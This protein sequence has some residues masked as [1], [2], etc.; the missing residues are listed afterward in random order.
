MRHDSLSWWRCGLLGFFF[1][2]LH[3]WVYD[4]FGRDGVDRAVLFQVSWVRALLAYVELPRAR[5]RQMPGAAVL[6]QSYLVSAL[7][8]QS[9]AL[10]HEPK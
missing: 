6:A 8:I 7:I 10:L 2:G 5:L 9:R 3:L 1:S 4:L